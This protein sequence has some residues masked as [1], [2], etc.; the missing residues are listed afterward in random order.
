[1][2]HRLPVLGLL[3]ALAALTPASAS[4]A[5]A[6]PVLPEIKQ[7]LADGWAVLR[8][9]PAM[10]RAHAMAVLGSED[11]TVEVDLRA[12]PADRRTACRAAVDGALEAW[13]ESVGDGFQ[14]RRAQDGRRCAIV[15][16]FQPE[17]R[18]NGE[19]VAG[20]VNWKR[21]ASSGEGRMTGDVQVRTI[22]LDGSPMPMRAMRHIVLHE[23]G[24]LLGLDDSSREG[25]A[26]GPLDVSHPVS[27]PTEAEASAVSELRADAEQLLRDAR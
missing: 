20:Y 4:D 26:M 27:M 7:H 16:R 1:M 25:E 14:A 13:E 10:A 3:S 22:N 11:V 6:A 2:R 12:V 9:D 24:H 19:P 5:F 17:V 8:R 15:V 18:E 23:M 21:T